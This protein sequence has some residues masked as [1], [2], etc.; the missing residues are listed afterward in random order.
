MYISASY[1]TKCSILRPC[2]HL[3]LLAH[4]HVS[5]ADNYTKLCIIYTATC[6]CNMQLQSYILIYTTKLYILHVTTKLY[7]IYTTKLYILHATTKLYT[8]YTTKLYI[9]HVTTKLYILH[10]AA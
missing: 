3:S 7:T 2:E 9:L 4:R 6:S 10:A 1:F 5:L 8:I